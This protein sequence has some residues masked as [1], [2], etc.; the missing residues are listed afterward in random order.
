MSTELIIF[1]VMAIALGGGLLYVGRHLYP[2]LDL[3]RDALST[4]RL[5]TAVIAGVLLLTGLGLVA[6][7][8]LT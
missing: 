8:L 6:V 4:V 7:G 1:G 5:L 2:R 3:T